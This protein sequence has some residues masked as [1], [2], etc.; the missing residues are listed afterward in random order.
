MHFVV[1][2]PPGTVW[3]AGVPLRA[4][5]GWGAHAAFMDR[6][7]EEGFILLGGPLGAAGDALHVC[8]ADSAESVRA[9]LA[10]DPWSGSVLGPETVYAWQILLGEESPGRLGRARHH[11]FCTLSEQG[12]AWRTG[13]PMRDQGLWREHA[14]FM[15]ALAE[16]GF[17]PI[18]GP[19]EGED[20]VHRALL[21]VDAASEADARDRLEPD[22]WVVANLLRIRTL[23]PWTILLGGPAT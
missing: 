11:H 18:G 20:G 4:Q 21:V 13:V 23:A 6:L 1:V 19:L 14:A 12:S 15:N 2:R 17:I 7:A 8:D 10:A 9:R 3:Q 16:D 22:P 5:P